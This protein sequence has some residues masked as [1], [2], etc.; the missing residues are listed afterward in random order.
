MGPVV[1]E[2]DRSSLM[3]NT[4]R[5]C[6]LPVTCPAKWLSDKIKSK[7]INVGEIA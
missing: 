6:C 4:R 7:K 2:W 5:A 1:E 3:I